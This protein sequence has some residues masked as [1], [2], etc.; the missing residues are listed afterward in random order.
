MLTTKMPKNA[1][2]YICEPCNFKC[3]KL[4][5]Y[6]THILTA[7]HKMLTNANEKE[8][9]N[10]KAFMCSCGKVYKQ[11]PSLTRNRHHTFIA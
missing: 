8:P 4:S 3:S 2:K 7:K 9:K 1:K 11:A 5:N 6:E 10:A